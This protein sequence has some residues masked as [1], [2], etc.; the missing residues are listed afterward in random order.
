MGKTILI[1]LALVM[2]GVLFLWLQNGSS[3]ESPVTPEVTQIEGDMISQ[4]EAVLPEIIPI[5]HA[6]FI[7]DYGDL[8]LYNDP[9]GGVDAFAG[10]KPAD[11]VLL[12]DTHGDHLN[13]ETLQAVIGENTKLIVPQAV[14]D[15][16]PAELAA[17]A[18]IMNNDESLTLDEYELTIN[19]IPMYNTEDQ[20]IEI[21]HV[22][23]VGNGYILE[24]SGS[25]IYIA[26]DT[27]NT[28]EMRA[29]TD[30]DVAFV[31]MNLPYTMS[32]ED[33]A[34]GVVAFKPAKVYPYHFRTPDGPSDV[35]KFKTLVNEAASDVEVVL[36]NWYPE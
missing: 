2:L 11:I 10:Q 27:A 19:A 12:S 33:A 35:N 36:L 34:A 30:I 29:L 24:K 23:G 28:P 26:G 20:G 8:V 14:A 1:V 21:R 6:T 16:L 18:T 22:K 5:S 31:P 15:E 7:L 9:V 4:A 25:R 13:L 3:K 17:K 32:V